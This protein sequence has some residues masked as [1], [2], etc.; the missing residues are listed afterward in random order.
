MRSCDE[1]GGLAELAQAETCGGT[2]RYRVAECRI[3]A[4]GRGGARPNARELGVRAARLGRVSDEAAAPRAATRSRSSQSV[5]PSARC[6][7]MP[8][9]E[10]ADQ[11]R[12][13]V[14][15]Q[16]RIDEA[17]SRRRPASSVRTPPGAP[18][19]IFFSAFAASTV[20]ARER[21]DVEQE[22]AR[23]GRATRRPIPG[24]RVGELSGR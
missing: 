22:T 6:T 23:A 11:P 10:A 19:T 16:L 13:F 5:S 14:V 18:A 3:G 20:A 4:L 1:A 21:D 9:C 12:Q 15:R 7:S 17:G 8:N 24:E 2:A